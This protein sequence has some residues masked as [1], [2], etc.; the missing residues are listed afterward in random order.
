M[1]SKKFYSSLCDT[2]VKFI[3]PQNVG[4]VFMHSK[5]IFLQL[6][7]FCICDCCGRYVNFT[8]FHGRELV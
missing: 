2:A 6:G 1:I 3:I 7:I 8:L 4:H 5:I